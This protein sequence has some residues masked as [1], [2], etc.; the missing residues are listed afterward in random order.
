MFEAEANSSSRA[1]PKA[2]GG[3]D[4]EGVDMTVV[5][6]L[7]ADSSSIGL[8]PTYWLDAVGSTTLVLLLRRPTSLLLLLHSFGVDD[9][10]MMLLVCVVVNRVVCVVVDRVVCLLCCCVEVNRCHWIFSEPVSLQ[11]SD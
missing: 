8:M 3:G 6:F 5:V 1:S 11:A 2:I 7:V 10:W 4:S 9:V